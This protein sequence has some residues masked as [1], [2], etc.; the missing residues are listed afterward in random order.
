[1]ALLAGL[2]DLQAVGHVPDGAWVLDTIALSNS[3]A[4]L[5]Y[6]PSVNWIVRANWGYGSTGTLPVP[7][8]YPEYVKRLA[9][10]VS[11]SR[12]CTRWII[13]NEPSLSREWPDGQPIFPHQ[14]AKCYLMARAAIHA[15]SG[16]EHDEVLI[17]SSGPWNNELKY[18]GNPNGDWITCFEDVIDACG[19]AIDGFSIHSYTHGYNVALVTSSARM[20]APFQHRHFEFRTYRD[21]MEAI[22]EHLRH[23][24]VYLTEANGNGP[25]QAVGL[26]PAMLNEID[27]W[28]KSGAQPIE[29][30]IFYRFP[31]YDDFYMQGR[32]DVMA[33]F[34]QAAKGYTTPATA[35]TVPQETL[36]MPTVSAPVRHVPP[37]DWD[38]RLT[39][40]GVTVSPAQEQQ[41][42]RITKAEYVPD[43]AQ[44]FGPDHH[45]LVEVLGKDGNRKM[46]VP[47]RFTWGSGSDVVA[48]NKH[49]GPYA[50]DFGMTAAG[51][52][53]G[54]RIDEE[55]AGSDSVFG[56]GLGKIGSEHMGDHVTYYLVF[57]EVEGQNVTQ[58]TLQ[59]APFGTAYVTV[60]AGAN[61][62]TRPVDGAI[63]IAVPYGEK[64]SVLGYDKATQW[65]QVRYG[66]ATGWTLASLLGESAPQ[67]AQ[68]IPTVP[69]PT[70]PSDAEQAW[71]RSIAF[72]LKEEGGLSTDKNDPG[73]YVN[74]V[75]VGTNFGISANAHPGVDIVNLTV[76]QAKA[77]YRDS[78][79]ISSGAS[80]LPWPMCLA[81]M[82]LA[83]NGGVG[84]AK[85]ALKESGHDF[86]KYMAWRIDWY[87]RIKDFGRYG[88]A[89]VRRCS[90]LMVE[91]TK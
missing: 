28:N 43:G 29:A 84:R 23:L 40:R 44:R 71:Q 62:R 89:W 13:G 90:R 34:E 14:Y 41:A 56:M 11:G 45:I 81:V 65:F 88:V 54:V 9:I 51:H 48:T 69:Q 35:A 61:V 68:P 42:W 7:D 22:P 6:H 70:A 52:S 33:E 91:A 75:F 74:G 25:W 79:W 47:V 19:D 85:E 57:R 12:G 46:G 4:P 18:A 37:V 50:A 5:N 32:G 8:Q 17:A 60:P 16:H 27:N 39:A 58:P 20:Q 3:P 72:V 55:G 82:D 78:Y 24:P 66:D 38:E 26:I 86:V 15:L 49:G 21:Y 36:H 73:N 53:Y 1:M 59:P 83:V 64:V 76:E 2:H 80:Q 63:L 30:L 31:R 77:I 10:Y 67:Q 87:T